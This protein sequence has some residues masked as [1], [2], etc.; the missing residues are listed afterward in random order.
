MHFLYPLFLA[1]LGAVAVP[2]IIHMVLKMK[3]RRVPFPSVRFLRQVE[4]KVARRQQIQEIL[5]LVI[6]CLL[7][8]FLVFALAGPIY[9][10][11]GGLFGKPTTAVVI[12]LDDSYSMAAVDA[13]GPVFD[14]GKALA[15]SIVRTLSPGNMC[16]IVTTTDRGGMTRDT[17]GVLRSLQERKPSY[18]ARSLRGPVEGALELLR[19]AKAVTRELYIV[20]DFQRRAV[21]FKGVKWKAKSLNVFLVPVRTKRKDNAT[22]ESLEQISPFATTAAPFRVRIRVVNQGD[23]PA[24]A[25]LK[26]SCDG[27][28][29]AEQPVY[30]AGK[31]RTVLS[32]DVP[33][34]SGGAHR[35]HAE[36][37]P[38]ALPADDAR[39]LAVEAYQEVSVL[40]CRPDTPDS[41]PRSFYVE[42]ALN[43]GYEAETGV[44]VVT[45]TPGEL[46]GTDASDY[47]VI[48][49][50]EA[51]PPGSGDRA[52]LEN[53]VAAGGSLVLV[54]GPDMDGGAFN[55]VLA[56]NGGGLG[57]LSPAAVTGV[58]GDPSRPETFLTIGRV[59][60]RHPVIARLN[61]GEVPVELGTA[62][63]Y[64]VCRVRPFTER[65]TSV[66]ASFDNGEPAIVERPYG[67]GRVVLIASSLHT[68]E[69]NLPVKVGFLP[70]MHSMV[71]WLIAGG[72]GADA[73]GIGEP[74]RLVLPKRDAA[75]SAFL[76]A[77]SGEA[78]EKTPEVKD[79]HA[80]Y[81]FGPAAEP[82]FCSL[83]WAGPDGIASR[84]IAV[85][86]DSAESDP[87][88]H[89]LSDGIPG[90]KAHVVEKG[91][92]LAAMIARF[93]TGYDLTGW[94]WFLVL[95]LALTEGFLANRFAF[96]K[97]KRSPSAPAGGA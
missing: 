63:F 53:Y 44:E 83:E 23:D 15:A 52:L 97:Q 41:L 47:A 55:E 57:P 20:S 78:V 25:S 85:N 19:D 11:T 36:L 5:L 32:L 33:L 65:D 67:M 12:V 13:E 17:T 26:V 51:C 75:P 4:R 38:D 1:G 94:A 28:A 16:A 76:T 31:S 81:D 82:G 2:V 29:I 3:A 40:L 71:A 80:R 18:G 70:L 77:A 89:D 69:T 46:G 54:A 59:D 39:F 21:D 62:A 72:T 30:V 91:E 49:L 66:V 96:G 56:A 43:P 50:V 58:E 60:P 92:D 34:E 68:D 88:M 6:R 45:C 22:L 87:E 8:M 93:R 86:V 35:I 24:T 7:I 90:V 10:P 74:L 64:R 95:L 79:E 37:E 42:R 84:L 27:M 61:R 73:V 14:R 48:F 9:K